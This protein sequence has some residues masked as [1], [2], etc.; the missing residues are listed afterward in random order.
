V[1]ASNKD[2]KPLFKTLVMGKTFARR[3]YGKFRN[4][5]MLQLQE[6]GAVKETYIASIFGQKP[7]AN[8]RGAFPGLLVL[9]HTG[10]YAGW[11]HP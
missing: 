9:H 8:R 3:G 6:G 11:K 4:Q 7:R 1:Y 2:G 5:R 10:A